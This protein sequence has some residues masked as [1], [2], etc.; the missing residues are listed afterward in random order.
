MVA[1]LWQRKGKISTFFE[2][3]TSVVLQ[4][5]Q[6][7]ERFQRKDSGIVVKF[8]LHFFK[9]RKCALMKREHC[10]PFKMIS[11][12]FN[13]TPELVLTLFGIAGEQKKCHFFKQPLT[14]PF[15]GHM[16]ATTCQID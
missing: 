9:G 5:C 7:K 1:D 14:L 16:S 3:I 6:N 12:T 4:Q 15:L 2:D 10:Q 13:M 11:K 8:S